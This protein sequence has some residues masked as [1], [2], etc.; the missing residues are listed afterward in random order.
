MGVYKE[1]GTLEQMQVAQKAEIGFFLAGG[2]E[3]DRGK[4]R[5]S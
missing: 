3:G 5:E 4:Q 2:W 1:P